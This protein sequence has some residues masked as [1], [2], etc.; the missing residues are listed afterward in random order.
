MRTLTLTEAQAEAAFEALETE[1]EAAFENLREAA[2]DGHN[3]ASLRETAE[4]LANVASAMLA[5]EGSTTT[6][7]TADEWLALARE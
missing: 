4:W 6:P 5:L 3:E 1:R 7:L 2:M